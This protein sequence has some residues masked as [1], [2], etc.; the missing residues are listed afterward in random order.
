MTLILG[1]FSCNK[2]KL[3]PVVSLVDEPG[4]QDKDTMLAVGDTIKVLIEYTWNGKHKV[5]EIEMKVNE[6][7][8]GNYQID[9]EQG[10][11]NITIIKGLA[12]TEIWDFTIIDVGGNSAT[13]SMNLT[14]DP[15]SI[16][17]GV[18]Y[19]DSIFLGAQANISKPGF[20]SISGSTYYTL[21]GAFNNQSKVD[22][23]FYYNSSDKATIASAG[24]DIPEGVYSNLLAP[25][26]WTVKNTSFFQKTVI[27]MEGFFGMF[28]DGFLIEN[29]DLSIASKKANNLVAGDIYLFQLENGKKGIF[30][31]ISVDPEIDGEV[32][33]AVKVQE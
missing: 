12:E 13:I 23:F 25:G 10:Q 22:F 1:F 24:A 8:I 18:K 9:Q 31:V 14:K 11:F 15:N 17:K 7:T 27:S 29:F 6:R 16:Y 5:S 33:I 19:Y 2:E 20:M 26:S 3:Q 32:N 30:Y 21:E 28:H 4:Y